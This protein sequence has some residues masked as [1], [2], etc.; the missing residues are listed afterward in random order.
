[1]GLIP[2][3]NPKPAPIIPPAEYEYDEDEEWE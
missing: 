2:D 3:V 1:M